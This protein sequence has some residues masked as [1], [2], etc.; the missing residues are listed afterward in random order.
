METFLFVGAI[1]ICAALSFSWGLKQQDL[2]R[3]ALRRL[4]T[5]V[6]LLLEHAG[7]Q[8]SVDL[9]EVHEALNKGEPIR[10]VKIYRE[11][12]GVDLMTA[13]LAVDEIQRAQT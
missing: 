4:D 10:A 1:V 7:L 9:T 2:Q 13:K 8:P 6:D 12:T 3:A 11:A 5:K